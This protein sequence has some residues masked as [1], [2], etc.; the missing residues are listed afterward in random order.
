MKFAK[1]YTRHGITLEAPRAARGTSML[2]P[3]TIKPKNHEVARSFTSKGTSVR[4]IPARQY[5]IPVEQ[6]GSPVEQYGNPA[7][8]YGNPVEQYGNP[9]EQ[10]G[11]PLQQPGNPLDNNTK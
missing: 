2:L 7:E 9:V 4:G 8:Q 11:N 10:R 5:G 6:Y 1:A 3:L